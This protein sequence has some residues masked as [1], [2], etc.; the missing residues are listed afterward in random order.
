MRTSGIKCEEQKTAIITFQSAYNYGAVLQAYALQE[1]L[2]QAFGNTRILDYHNPE[3][4]RSYAR[5][6]VADLFRTP[7][8]AIFRLIQSYL[9]RGK[10]L[11]IDRFRKEYLKL[12]RKYDSK[13][14]R[15]ANNEADVFVAGSDQIWNHLIIGNDT[16]F[17][18]D[19]IDKDKRTCSYAASIGVPHIPEK[20]IDLYRKAINHVQKI[21]VREKI[22][23]YC[24]T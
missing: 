13:S 21:S 17:F 2:T 10:N 12:T 16:S 5:P 4:D 22:F 15:S 14:I 3:I 7:K 9:Y 23:F 8:Q 19:F 18:L 20:Y 1:Y 11:R 24:I 6:K